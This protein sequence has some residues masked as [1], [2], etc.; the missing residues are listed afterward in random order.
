MSR[1]IEPKAK[2]RLSVSCN[3]LRM[4]LPEDNQFTLNKNIYPT[5]LRTLL[6]QNQIN[7][8]LDLKTLDFLIFITDNKCLAYV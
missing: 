4:L 2:R 3:K 1:F 5:M 7:L 8:M 6:F